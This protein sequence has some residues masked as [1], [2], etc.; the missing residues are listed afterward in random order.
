MA[1]P[2]TPQATSAAGHAQAITKSDTT[3]YSPPLTVLYVGGAGDVA[4]LCAA[5]G[6]STGN[7]VT[8]KAVPVGTTLTGFAIV[9]VMSTNTTAT[10]LVGGW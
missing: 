4:I 9:R 8:L 7:A 6:D 5:Q 10:L 2:Y 3:V 1:A